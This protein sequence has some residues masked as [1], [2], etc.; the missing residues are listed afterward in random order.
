[1]S[2]AASDS[3]NKENKEN[4]SQVKSEASNNGAD[5]EMRDTPS[6]SVDNSP[7]PAPVPISAA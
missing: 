5:V 2:A 3:S 1:V 4:N 6:F 7:A